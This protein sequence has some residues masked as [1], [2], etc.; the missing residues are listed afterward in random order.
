MHWSKVVTELVDFVAYFLAIGAVG[1]RYAA[2]RRRIAGTEAAAST[3]TLVY[4]DALKRAAI[5]GLV[6]AVMHGAMFLEGLPNAA[7]RAHT[8]AAQLLTGDLQTGLR[9]LLLLAAIIG[10]ALA[11]ARRR[12]GWPIAAIGVVLDPFV[13]ILSGKWTR[14]INPVHMFVGG[15]WLGTLFVLVVAG[16]VSVLRDE[17]SPQRRGALVAEMVNGFSP[18]ALTCGLV[19]VASGLLTAWRHLN[20]LSSLWSTPY[21]YA[22]LFKLCLVAVVFALGAWNWRRQRPQLGSEEAAVAIRHS[23]VL[24]LAVATLVLVA[25]SV[26]V[27]LPSPRPPRPPGAQPPGSPPS[28]NGSQLK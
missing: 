19:L 14:L 10:F 8:S 20:P 27:S 24:E 17:R 28:G 23:S 18:V 11:S 22:L 5:I 21:G 6:G 3:D 25:T 26:L 16:I 4:A 2:V 15:L 13:P 12:A 9:A 1:F 7:A